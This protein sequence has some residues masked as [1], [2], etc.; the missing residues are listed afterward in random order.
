[1]NIPGLMNH[2]C[3]KSNLEVSVFKEL[4]VS[5]VLT[6]IT[7]FVFA[8]KGFATEKDNWQFAIEPYLMATSI[9]GDAS[10]GRA[11]GVDVDVRFS[12]ILE[13]LEAAFMISAEAYHKS[14]WGN[15]R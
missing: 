5:L 15:T 8:D 10:I 3:D 4:T 12:D 14:G 7:F 11:T 6:I 9:E 13:T 2:C 1:V